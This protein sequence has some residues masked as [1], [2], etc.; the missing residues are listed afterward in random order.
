MIVQEI[1]KDVYGIIMNDWDKRLF[2]ELI[3][4][5]DG[6]TYNAY[7]IKDKKSVLIDTSDPRKTDKFISIL[8]K[9]SGGKIDYV[10][11]N[12]SEQDHSGSIPAVLKEFSSA[13]VIT[14]DKGASLLNKLLLVPEDK[15]IRVKD[16]EEIDIGERKLK[17]F[18]TPWVHWPETII[19]YSPVDKVLFLCDLFGSHL[20]TGSF[21][22]SG[23]D[24]VYEAAKR[25]YAE[26]MMP[27]R[28]HI[29]KHLALI[30]GLAIDIIAP[31]HGPVYNN[32]QFIV[33]AYKDWVS[34]N[35]RNEVVVPYVSM[36]GSVN[37][38][39]DFFVDKLIERGIDAKPFNITV[40]DIGELAIS[41]VDTATVVLGT[42][43]VLGGPHPSA[44]Y[45]TYLFKALRPKT[46]FV[47]VINSF[48][49]GGNT[50]KLIT[51]M[52]PTGDIEILEPVIVNGYPEES[53]FKLLE[54]LAENILKKHRGLNIT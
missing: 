29:K 27:F 32:P 42:P 23:N 18:H 37:V 43:T 17:F 46:R 12:H 36:H 6:T 33:N 47:S 38:M 50:V 14:S 4:L 8:K 3:P 9:V 2:D 5:P 49:W 35:V 31:S 48:G 52:L 53:D 22:A 11:S 1:K 39:V 34:D 51:D 7:L 40:T 41:M 15:F 24:R 30:D 28:N 21:Y 16:G 44:I 45:V 10:I 19:T 13:R 54:N 25:Y 20:A 26:I